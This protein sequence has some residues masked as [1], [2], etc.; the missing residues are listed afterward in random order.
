M[1]QSWKKMNKISDLQ[2]LGNK[3][4]EHKGPK[5]SASPQVI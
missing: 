1:K 2:N 4:M 5:I 3:Q